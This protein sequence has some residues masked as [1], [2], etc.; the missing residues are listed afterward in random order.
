M[1]KNHLH[2]SV[3]SENL[4]FPEF[5]VEEEEESSKRT[6][7]VVDLQ[8]D[9]FDGAKK[10]KGAANIIEPIRKRIREYHD[11]GCGIIFLRQTYHKTDFQGE[12]GQRAT[13]PYCL[14]GTRGEEIYGG[15]FL[16]EAKTIHRTGLGYTG[17][18]EQPLNEV[19]F[20]GIGTDTGIITNALL[21]R[22]FYPEIP[23]KVNLRCVAGTTPSGNQAALEVMK[24]CGITLM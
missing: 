21:L 20:V 19:E 23:V 1:E 13:Q 3:H 16:E 22:T 14:E 6:L 2:I 18:P 9:F 4:A 12:V 5:V 10:I 17:W 7:I 8:N 15:L 24:A 11:Y